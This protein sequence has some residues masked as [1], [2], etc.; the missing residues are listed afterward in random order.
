MHNHDILG[1]PHIINSNLFWICLEF[2]MHEDS[3]QPFPDDSLYYILI[4]CQDPS[5]KVTPDAK[6][7]RSTTS[8]SIS[9]TPSVIVA[10]SLLPDLEAAGL[11]N[12]SCED[13]HTTQTHDISLD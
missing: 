6:I 4:P 2:C 9:S 3:N 8:S 1:D 10:K 13:H 12:F 5:T 7:S 11:C